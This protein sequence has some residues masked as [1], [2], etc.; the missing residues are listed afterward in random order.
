MIDELDDSAPAEKA[1]DPD[2]DPGDSDVRPLPSASADEA[3]SQRAGG[4]GIEFLADVPLQVEIRLG[5][6]Q[7]AIGE[8]LALGPGAVVALERRADD[9]VEV[10]A[11]GRVI[12]RG[13]MVVVDDRLGVR[14]TELCASE[15]EAGE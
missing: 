2:G 7:M 13:E 8:L 6:A 3:V 12:A 15:G 1:Q 9:P 10:V 11:G 5:G 14:V 4:E